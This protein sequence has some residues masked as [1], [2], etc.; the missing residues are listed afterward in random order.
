[1]F[2]TMSFQCLGW[3]KNLRGVIW[4]SATFQLTLKLQLL[5]KLCNHLQLMLKCL[6]HLKKYKAT[7]VE[8]L[9]NGE[10]P[11][12]MPLLDSNQKKKNM[13]FV[14]MF[15]YLLLTHHS[16]TEPVWQ[17][18]KRQLMQEKGLYKKH[19][20]DHQLLRAYATY[21][22]KDKGVENYKQ[23]VSSLCGLLICLLS[24]S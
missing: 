1:M 16:E 4:W 11:S 12:H 5:N 7:A 22:H 23:D 8:R 24:C 6:N 18:E 3:F 13:N 20:K 2:H 21:L 14:P 9:F 15:S 17:S 10:N 19:S